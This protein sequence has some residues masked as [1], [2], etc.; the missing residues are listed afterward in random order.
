MKKEVIL[1]S[2]ESVETTSWHLG[3]HV[4]SW[5]SDVGKESLPDAQKYSSAHHL[6]PAGAP[7]VS[8]PGSPLSYCKQKCWSPARAQRLCHT[9][10]LGCAGCQRGQPATALLTTLITGQGS[11]QAQAG[12]DTFHSCRE[13]TLELPATEELL[14]HKMLT[15]GNGGGAGQKHSAPPTP[16][17]GSERAQADSQTVMATSDR[18]TKDLRT[19]L[20]FGT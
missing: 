8:T 20:S 10:R 2:L 16:D 11:P 14:P 3:R 4:P 1:L 15:K 13:Q 12:K 19:T 18:R 17:N 5:N 6:H 7:G 9:R